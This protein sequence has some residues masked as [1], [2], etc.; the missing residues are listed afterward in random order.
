MPLKKINGIDMF[1]DETGTGEPLLFIHGIGSSARD[2]ELQVPVFSDRYRVITIDLRGH[3]QTDKPKTKYSIKQFADDTMQLLE[4]LD[5]LPV[6]IVGLSL[7][8]MVAFQMVV[9]RPDMVKSLTIVNSC[10][11]MIIHKFNEWI[12]FWRRI[13][14]IRLV[15]MQR[16][17][18]FLCRRLFPEPHQEEVR[19]EAIRR[20]TANDKRAYISTLRA[21]SGWSVIDR[22]ERITCPTLLL[23]GELDFLPMPTKQTCVSKIAQSEL[24]IIDNS[25]HMTPVDQPEKFNKALAEFLLKQEQ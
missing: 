21:I 24:M 3:G 14:T 19:C 7:G 5:A 23:S 20:L 13:V 1:Y 6:H 22:I 2:W 10:P 17:A 4:S 12:E 9:D 15:G 8:G 18:K 11:E 16:L 25:R